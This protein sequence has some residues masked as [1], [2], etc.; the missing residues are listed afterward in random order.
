M[1][2]QNKENPADLDSLYSSDNSPLRKNVKSTFI[3]D[4]LF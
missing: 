1:Q 4:K 3:Q 2:L